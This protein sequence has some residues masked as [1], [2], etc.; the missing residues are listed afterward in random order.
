M[1]TEDAVRVEFS[2]EGKEFEIL[3]NPDEALDYRRNGEG[4]VSKI[5]FVREIFKDASTGD[6]A[7]S[8]DL[9]EFLGTS[10]I[11][12]AAEKI[13]NKGRM[14]LTTKQKREMKEEKRKRI[15][16]M[17]SRRA[18]NPQTDS[19]HPPKRIENAME[20]ARV[21]IDPMESPEEQ[22]QR[23]VDKLRPILPISFEKKKI[24]VKI[25]NKY[26]GKAYGTLKE[27]SE[28]LDE[29]WGNEFLFA[30]LKIPAGIEPELMDKL[31]KL[32]SGEVEVK[33]LD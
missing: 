20:E 8:K 11:L 32:T 13:L 6:K 4:D 1:E 15:V 22:M 3:V 31:N 10:D 18:K 33:E 30:K 16:N 14:Q 29:E 5:L 28:V 17:I 9:K 24:A 25:P 19:P 12:E 2:K 27:S 7:S 26:S 21:E 23:I